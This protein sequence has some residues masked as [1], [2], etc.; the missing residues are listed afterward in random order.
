MCLL[1]SQWGE[2]DNWEGR[3]WWGRCSGASA[4]CCPRTQTVGSPRARPSWA[5]GSLLERG[6]SFLMAQCN[7]LEHS[8]LLR[9]WQKLLLPVTTPTLCECSARPRRQ[10]GLVVHRR[11]GHPVASSPGGCES[12]PSPT[13][14]QTGWG[15][16][17]AQALNAKLNS[18]TCSGQARDRSRARGFWKGG[19]GCC[20]G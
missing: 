20:C 15:Q 10:A 12:A 1:L 9:W 2:G 3:M 8:A 11:K 6:V 4:N 18:L 14:T 16:G 13:Q 7:H 19:R 17:L 5:G